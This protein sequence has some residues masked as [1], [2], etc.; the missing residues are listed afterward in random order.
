MYGSDID[1]NR[2][3]KS[4]NA[5]KIQRQHVVSNH[6]PSLE[7]PGDV[8]SF[9]MPKLGEHDMIVPGS[10]YISFKLDV[11]SDKD[12]KRTIVQNIGRKIAK[13]W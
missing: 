4:I 8:I 7:K 12:K 5:P 2:T 3:R 9:E 6:T 11:K 10:F 1:V 13:R